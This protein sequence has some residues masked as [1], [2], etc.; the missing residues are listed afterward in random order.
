[1]EAPLPDDYRDRPVYWCMADWTFP[2]GN[3]AAYGAKGEVTGPY[4]ADEHPAVSV[5]FPG[6][7]G[8]VGCRLAQ[9]SRSWPPPPL[10]GGWK[11]NEAASFIGLDYT[12]PNGTTWAHGARGV[13]AG[14]HPTDDKKVVVR[15][16]GNKGGV[17]CFIADLSRTPPSAA[18]REPA[19]VAG[20]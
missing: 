14:P 10:P 11:V 2:S 18:E 4:T 12:A 6:N 13:V 3:T 20:Q 7:K 9:L 16:P 19:Q 5:L 17:G 8:T 15:F 1:M